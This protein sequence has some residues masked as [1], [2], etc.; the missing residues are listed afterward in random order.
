MKNANIL[1]RKEVMKELQTTVVVKQMTSRPENN[2]L[3][4]HMI[5]RKN[6]K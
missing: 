5:Q 1:M 2:V 4:L 6:L 3:G